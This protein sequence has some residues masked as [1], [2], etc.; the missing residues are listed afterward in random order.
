MS[1]TLSLHDALP[2]DGILLASC[3]DHNID[4]IDPCDGKRIRS[5]RS[6]KSLAGTVAFSQDRTRIAGLLGCGA[7][8]LWDCEAA[9]PSPLSSEEIFSGC[10]AWSP[11]RNRLA[12]VSKSGVVGIWDSYEGDPAVVF[13]QAS[14]S[15]THLV[16]SADGLY[17]ASG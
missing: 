15:V 14:S 8:A 3:G 5:I 2:I 6:D 13:H 4:L 9:E 12:A 11:D 17:V 7:V 16:W 10:V 1:N